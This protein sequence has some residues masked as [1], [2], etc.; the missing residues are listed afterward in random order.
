MTHHTRTIVRY[1]L[2]IGIFIAIQAAALLLT[3]GQLDWAAAWIYLAIV[4]ASQGGVGATLARKNPALLEE[5][6]DLRGERNLDRRLAGVMAFF[7]PLATCII[8]GLQLR[9]GWPPE[10]P[11][12]AQI[13]GMGIALLGSGWTVW[14]MLTNHFFYGVVRCAP[15]QGHTVCD[16]GPYRIVRHPGYGGAILFNLG[17]P[18]LLDSA[19][20]FLPAGLTVCAIVIRTALE[21]RTL[22]EQLP[23]YKEYTRQV[24]SRLLPGLW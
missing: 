10:F 2:Q 14:A 17:V 7:G 8:A 15:E 19:W 12:C 20:A 4:A 11:L 22:Q 24:R 1:F 9:G 18:L 6:S 3:A 16:R 21:D 13:A 23:G 5:R